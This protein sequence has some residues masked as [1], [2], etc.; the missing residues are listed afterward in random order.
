MGCPCNP[1]PHLISDCAFLLLE[2]VEGAFGKTLQSIQSVEAGFFHESLLSSISCRMSR[3]K[4]SVTSISAK[5]IFI[6]NKNSGQAVATL[7][8]AQS[9]SV[10]YLHQESDEGAVGEVWQVLA[11]ALK[12]K[13][14]EAKLHWVAAPREGW[15]EGS[16]ED[17]KDIWDA[18]DSGFMVWPG[19][20]FLEVDKSKYD[21]DDAWTFVS[22]GLDG[23]R[24][25]FSDNLHK[26]ILR[27]WT[28]IF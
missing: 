22:R 14:D 19:S 13:P 18:A 11:R 8:Q 6:G 16:M 27:I 28:N 20:G 17:I 12:G 2:L 25:I 3:M 24:R 9:F 1:K 7:L 15:A 10:K 4:E 21:R 5:H 23:L 26:C